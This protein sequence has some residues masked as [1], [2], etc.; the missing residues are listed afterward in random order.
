MGFLGFGGRGEE[1]KGPVDPL[2][3]SQDAQ[4]REETERLQALRDEVR[5]RDE[6]RGLLLQALARLEP[7]QGAVTS[8]EILFELARGPLDVCSY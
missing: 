4:A 3:I 2:R 6:D 7:G 8:A 5:V 1:G